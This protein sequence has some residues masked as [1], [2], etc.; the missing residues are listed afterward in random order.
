[1]RGAIH[2][3]RTPHFYLPFC[4]FLSYLISNFK[5]GFNALMNGHTNA[6]LHGG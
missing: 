2:L 1:M 6:Q 5:P 3:N 4:L